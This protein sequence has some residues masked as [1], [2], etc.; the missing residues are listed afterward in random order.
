MYVGSN[1]VSNRNFEAGAYS[2]NSRM[3][4]NTRMPTCVPMR[5]YACLSRDNARYLE[6]GFH[7]FPKRRNLPS[8][9]GIGFEN[10]GYRV[11]RLIGIERG[12]RIKALFFSIAF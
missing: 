6:N 2:A 9:R 10:W 12:E 7:R 11:A 8:P 4:V 1:R 3:I 5:V